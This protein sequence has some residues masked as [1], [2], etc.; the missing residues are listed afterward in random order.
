M[1]LGLDL[2]QRNLP[3]RGGGASLSEHAVPAAGRRSVPCLPSESAGTRPATSQHRGCHRSTSKPFNTDQPIFPQVD[4]ATAWS[5]DLGR[6]LDYLEIR[7]DI[8]NARLAY[9][10]FSLGGAEGP[11]LLAMEK[12]IKGCG[13]AV[14]RISEPAK[15]A[16]GGC[17]QLC[18]PRHR[19]CAD[20][21]WP[22]R[23]RLPGGVLTTSDVSASGSPRLETRSTSSTTAAMAR[24]PV[25]RLCG[26]PLT[27]ST[28]TSALCV[29]KS[30]GG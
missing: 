9:L 7:K 10:G 26:R 1:I 4:H 15:P 19:T 27:G 5:K 29:P 13:V 18:R 28:S 6:T 25:L 14:R 2:Y 17:L 20:A 11:M 12:R 16:G 22:I 30:V 24:S 23:H 8:D 21:Q 3:W